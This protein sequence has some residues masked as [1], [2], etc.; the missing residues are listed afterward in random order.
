MEFPTEGKLK[1]WQLTEDKLAE[2][3]STYAHLDVRAELRKARQWLRDNP[4]KR[5]TPNGMPRFLSSWLSRAQ[6]GNG[7]RRDNPTPF[8][9][10]GGIDP[11]AFELGDD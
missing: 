1:A 7:Q 3:E 2:Y 9:E 8:G 6:N 4:A 11:S 10:R 5:K